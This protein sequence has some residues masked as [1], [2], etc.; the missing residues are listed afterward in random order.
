VGIG[1]TSASAFV[2]PKGSITHSQAVRA[3][4]RTAV[5]MDVELDTAIRNNVEQNT[6]PTGQEEEMVSSSPRWPGDKGIEGREGVFLRPKRNVVKMQKDWV[7][8]RYVTATTTV[9]R[10]S[11]GVKFPANLLFFRPRD[12]SNVVIAP[13]S[14]A[15][16]DMA[17]AKGSAAILALLLLLAQ[18]IV[19]SGYYSVQTDQSYNN[20]VY[21]TKVDKIGDFKETVGDTL[22]R[23][24]QSW[25]KATATG[26]E[27]DS[28]R[29]RNV[30]TSYYQSL[31]AMEPID[32]KKLQPASST[33]AAQAEAAEKA[34]IKKLKEATA[35]KDKKTD[36]VA[37]AK[38]K[39]AALPAAA[40]PTKD[41]KAPAPAGEKSVPAVAD[42]PAPATV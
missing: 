31:K 25:L 12:L 29:K 16:G 4:C 13:S 19:Q 15:T 27:D 35:T 23:Y 6:E 39:K 7:G 8:G 9:N 38:G 10:E 36:P 21:V 33:P 18:P 42:V 26:N 5:R 3:I 30:P 17:A 22:E 28:N 34:A 32:L 2:A 41:A 40:A 1:V 24:V 11:R 14:A 20:F 37:D